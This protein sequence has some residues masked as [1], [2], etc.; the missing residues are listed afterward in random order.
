MSIKKAPDITVEDFD[1]ILIIRVN[2]KGVCFGCQAVLRV[3]IPGNKRKS[4]IL[5]HLLLFPSEREFRILHM[6]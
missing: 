5:H 4:S 2:S 1:P 3:T 6:P